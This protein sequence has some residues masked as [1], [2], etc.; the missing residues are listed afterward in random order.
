MVQVCNREQYYQCLLWLAADQ[1]MANS[2][3][4]VVVV[5]ATYHSQFCWQENSM[6]PSLCED[7][8]SWQ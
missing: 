8:E 6:A 2:Q 7:L 3:S 5:A 1:E 4:K